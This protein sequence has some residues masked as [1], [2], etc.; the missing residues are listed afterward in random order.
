M[1]NEDRSLI[2]QDNRETN[3]AKALSIKIYEPARTQMA[4]DMLKALLR[5]LKWT[6]ISWIRI[7]FFYS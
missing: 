7:Q 6:R 2:S 5:G 3:K 1:E 4:E